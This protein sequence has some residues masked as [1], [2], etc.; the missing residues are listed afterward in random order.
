VID[1]GEQKRRLAEYWE[2]SEGNPRVFLLTSLAFWSLY[3][4]YVPTYLPLYLVE[5]GVPKDQV[6]AFNAA[7]LAVVLLGTLCSGW[8]ARH[9][10]RHMLIVFVADC[11][12]FPLASLLWIFGGSKSI[13][14]AGMLCNGVYGF[15]TAAF[16]L[17][18]SQGVSRDDLPKV[19]TFQTMA[20]LAAG[21]LTPLAGLFLRSHPLVQVTRWV[22]GASSVL[23]MAGNFVR[24]RF[25]RESEAQAGPPQGARRATFL[26]AAAV[27]R[28][29]KTSL[30][31]LLGMWLATCFGFNLCFSY[32]SI[33]F[34]DP[35][36]L[37]LS[38]A[39]I[40]LQGGLGSALAVVVTLW[41]APHFK[42]ALVTRLIRL[43]FFL[44]ALYA[45]VLALAPARSLI[46]V[47]TATVLGSVGTLTAL[48]LINSAVLTLASEANKVL[49]A[50]ACGILAALAMVPAGPVAGWLYGHWVRGPFTL[51]A[52]LYA[53]IWLVSLKFEFHSEPQAA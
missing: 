23:V 25:M 41:A 31:A 21:L 32:S 34:T 8:L 22:L 50:S 14:L 9:S 26:Q 2:R 19:F 35:A 47:L 43:S 42:D 49:L 20:A 24:L 33:F 7:N 52:A 13:L 51:A 40:S 12:T 38:P 3:T 45:S 5:R 1:L 36:G 30:L 18:I 4:A 6:G 44:L 27:A 39:S 28:E 37:D 17:L 16:N 53:L 15:N 29:E 46:W 11:F 10:R 48:S